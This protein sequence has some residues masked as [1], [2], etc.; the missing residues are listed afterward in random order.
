MRK[1]NIFKKYRFA[2]MFSAVALSAICTPISANAADRSD[3]SNTGI[4][5]A[6]SDADS[7]G[8]NTD[9]Y[10]YGTDS[11]DS[12]TDNYDYST[13]TD[14]STYSS[15][16]DSDTYDYIFGATDF[17]QAEK[18]VDGDVTIIDAEHL[19]TDTDAVKESMQAFTTY[20]KAVFI[21]TS[22]GYKDA[23]SIESV[24]DDY[25]GHGE[26]GILF[27]IDMNSRQ[28]LVYTD[29]NVHSVINEAYAST[30]TDNVY[31]KASNGDYDATVI[32]IFDMATNL[33]SGQKVAQPMRAITSFFMA[34]CTAFII[35]FIIIKIAASGTSIK[36]TQ[37]S[38]D[39]IMS[40]VLFSNVYKHTHEHVSSTSVGGGSSSG[41]G[42]GGGG[43][44]S[45]GG[46]GH[47]F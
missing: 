9:S 47:S 41:G 1:K 31:K 30:I 44:H 45:G 32:G 38:N 28:L 6:Y 46:G 15:D 40:R 14:D 7:D 42:G 16:Y 4:L 12:T 43:G 27:L 17:S 19:L 39:K 23:A 11:Y 10:D 21:S 33:M 8:F 35:S 36:Q 2:V 34:I 3:K 13:D 22:E 25:I 37:I 18:I 29:G 24:Y 20:G 5:Y 26:D